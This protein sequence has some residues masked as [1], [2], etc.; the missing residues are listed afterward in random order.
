MKNKKSFSKIWALCRI[1]LMTALLFGLFPG[2]AGAAEQ[3]GSIELKLPAEYPG[4]EMTL[5]Q[6]AENKDGVFACCNGFEESGV[7][8][9]E[10]NEA[11]RLAEAA[12]QL[13][14][15]AREKNI[16]GYSLSEDGSGSY[17]F[18]NLVPG[19]YLAVQT[20][21][22]DALQVQKVFAPIPYLADDK[23][24]SSLN[25]VVAPKYTVPEGAVILNKEDDGGKPV[26]QARFSLQRKTYV[27]ENGALPEGAE[28]GQD[29]NGR[30]FWS[31][32]E[33]D[34]LTDAAGQIVRTKMPLGVYRFV[35]TQAPEG[36]ILSAEPHYFQ[37]SGAG[38]VEEVNGFWQ[39]GEGKA[40]QVSA[41]NNRTSVKVTKLDENGKLLPGAKMVIK[42]AQGNVLRDAQGKAAFI[43]TMAEGEYDL[44]QLPAGE[45]LLSELVAPEGYL[46]AKDV[47]LTVS[48]APDAENA[49]T[50]VDL[51]EKKTK[52]SL[53]VTKKLTDAFGNILTAEEGTF[54]VALFADE[55]HTE[56]VSS[57]QALSYKKAYSA[58]AVFKNLELDKPYYLG[59]TDESGNY[60][61]NKVT[62]DGVY[63]P[64]YPDNGKILL[65]AASPKK[66]YAFE[67]QFFELPDGFYYS[68]DITVTK[69]VLRGKKAVES[70][71]TYYA[72]IFTDQACT[73]KA[74]EVIEL[75]MDGSSEAAVKVENL[76]IGTSEADRVTYYIAE[77]DKNGVPLKEADVQFTFSVDK[78]QVVLSMEN[79][80]ETVTITNELPEN[81][82]AA[83][84]EA[85]ITP[86]AAPNGENPGQQTGGSGAAPV[87]TGDETQPA[88]YLLLLLAA[89]AV[90]YAALHMKK[91]NNK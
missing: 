42:D 89:A 83:T 56:R 12:E 66:E 51:P 15:F 7:T 27:T 81:T 60:Q 55:A 46:I 84:P 72:A 68:G 67:N 87:K 69:K 29:V 57:V 73:Q 52:G 45:Y 23:G 74:G 53:Q 36:F 63:Q 20:K 86:A 30:F 37:L 8:V 80:H 4:V 82:P 31:N 47:P 40:E 9:P 58:T 25:A 13:G 32:V 10:L 76:Y 16:P 61:E 71:E 5:Y 1:F 90:S 44:R 35:E 18:S 54:Y 26:G 49:V 19:L 2:R 50:M 22:E 33:T 75:K 38:Q 6:V 85:T 78:K 65:T 17:L 79:A 91:R 34:L 59:E 11:E 3:T 28:T 64:V 43:F 70:K 48:S 77:T 24:N 41:V 14:A 88:A 21:G 39:A 62:V